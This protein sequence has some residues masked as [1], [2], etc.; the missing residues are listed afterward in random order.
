MRTFDIPACAGFMLHEYSDEVVGFFKPGK[1]IDTF[2]SVEEC[3]DKIQY[4]LKNE[5]IREKL[6]LNGYNKLITAKY[7]YE[8]NINS[9]LDS[10]KINNL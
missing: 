10:L 8:S 3:S 7:N 1:E 6:A 9:I 4:Y 5:S 2:N